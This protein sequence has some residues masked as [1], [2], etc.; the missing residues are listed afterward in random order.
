MPIRRIARNAKIGQLRQ[1][2]KQ[3]K[4][5]KESVHCSASIG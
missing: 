3:N 1:K 5:I 2:T 4:T